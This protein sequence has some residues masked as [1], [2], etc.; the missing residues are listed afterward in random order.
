MTALDDVYKKFGE[1]AEA[2]QLLETEL[3]NILL[4]IQTEEKDLVQDKNPEVAQ[5]IVNKINKSTLGGLLREVEEKIGGQ[6]EFITTLE[7]ALK[8]RNKLSHS[9]YREHNFRRNTIAGRKQMLQ[10]LEEMHDKIIEA[11]KL[12]LALSGID[13]EKFKM[14]L[15]EKH[16]K[17]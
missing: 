1:T 16:I 3:G 7:Q 15:Q 6:E 14:P 8:A 4:F 12:T 11:Y 13:I 9:F 2:A 10:D 5:N 17:I